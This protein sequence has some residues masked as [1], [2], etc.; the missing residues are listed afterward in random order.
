MLSVSHGLLKHTELQ[1][2]KYTT[3]MDEHLFQ[4]SFE[5]WRNCSSLKKM[6]SSRKLFFSKEITLAQVMLFFKKDQ[7]FQETTGLLVFA[8]KTNFRENIISWP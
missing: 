7:N 5:S 4:D 2:D 6:I 1:Y 3:D 8:V